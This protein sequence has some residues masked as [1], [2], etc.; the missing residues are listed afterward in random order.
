MHHTGYNGCSYF[1]VLSQHDNFSTELNYNC[2][3]DITTKEMNCHEQMLD[4]M[5]KTMITTTSKDTSSKV[6]DG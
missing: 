4:L 1:T 5:T 3:M 6:M 2:P